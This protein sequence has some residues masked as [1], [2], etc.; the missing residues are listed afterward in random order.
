MF[1]DRGEQ[2]TIPSKNVVNKRP[3]Q[4]PV[5]IA[6]VVAWVVLFLAILVLSQIS[7]ERSSL[8]NDTGNDIVLG[9]AFSLQKAHFSSIRVFGNMPIRVEDGGLV[10]LDAAGREQ[11][12]IQYPYRH[13]Y[14]YDAGQALMIAPKSGTEITL[15]LPN[16]TT[17]EIG[18]KEIILGGDY[19][20]GYALTLGQSAKSVGTVSL[21]K[22]AQE[23]PILKLTI[24]EEGRPVRVS[25][26]KTGKQ[27]DV[28]LVDFTDGR[29]VTR[30][31]RYDFSG[32]LQ[33]DRRFPEQPFLPAM[34]HLD[35]NETV[36]YSDKDVMVVNEKTGEPRVSRFLELLM[37]LE[38][39]S[40]RLAVLGMDEGF[41][42]L[43]F[44]QNVSHQQEQAFVTA[45]SSNELISFALSSDGMYALGATKNHLMLF[46]TTTGK[47]IA[48]KDGLTNMERVLTLGEREFL[49]MTAEDASIVTIR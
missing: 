41:T 3:F 30:V 45:E 6:V 4:R 36:F 21:Y 9:E 18:V 19:R 33:F 11:S 31:L 12:F 1:V 38:M 46:D 16:L 14:L 37:Q 24:S 34:L 10:I 22:L 13:P 28:L 43:Q 42:T 49:I 5:V 20:D 26:T 7:R 32:E 8:P 40:G 35:E 25:F 15:V 44:L 39:Q 27:F 29:P 23:N 48:K 2:S 47:L 17:H